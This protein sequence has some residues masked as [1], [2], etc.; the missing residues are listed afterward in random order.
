VP[1]LPAGT[2]TFLF[3]DI[4]KSSRLLAVDAAEMR[5]ALTAH[6]D[7]LREAI[8]RNGG[9]VFETVGDAVYAAFAKPSDAL[10][11]ALASQRALGAE[12][13]APVGAIRARMAIHSG[14]VER[15]D[16]QHYVGEPLFRAGRLLVLGHGGQTLVSG[17]T[18]ML[19][20]ST[21]PASATLRDL[22]EHRLKDIPGYEHVFQLDHPGLTDSFPPLRSLDARPNNL[23]SPLTS[24]I[25]RDR[26]LADLADLLGKGR[27][28][29][30]TG[31]GG[32]GKTRLALELCSRALDGYPDGCWWVDLA[33]LADP[34]LVWPS[35]GTAIG[36]REQP[37]EPL[38]ASIVAYLRERRAILVLDNCEHLVDACAA[39]AEDLLHACHELRLVA[40]SRETLGVAGERVWRTPS[41]SE[42]VDLFLER[43]RATGATIDPDGQRAEIARV[44]ER[45][46]RLPLAIE[47]AAARTR[48]LSIQQIAERLD[49]RFRL[50]TGGSRTAVARQQTLSAAIDWSFSLLD[51]R[52]RVLWQ[53][54]SVF[55]GGFSIDAAERVCAGGEVSEVAILDIVTSLV[56]KSL[57]ITE[58]SARTAVR[59]RMLESLREY[60]GSRLAESGETDAIRSAH[61]DHFLA[62][63]ERGRQHVLG[64]AEQGLWLDRFDG[65]IDNFRAAFRWSIEHAPDV[66]LRLAVALGRFV[67][68]RAH[69]S[70]AVVWRDAILPHLADADAP[71]RAAAL[72]LAGTV[73][74]QRE[75]Y[76]LAI[77]YHTRAVEAFQALGDESGVADAL[78]ALGNDTARKGDDFASRDYFAQTLELDRRAARAHGIA[79]S[80]AGL[81][82]VAWRQGDY[83][84]ARQYYEEAARIRAELG[85]RLGV[86]QVQ[87]DLAHVLQELGETHQAERV[88]TESA[89]TFREMGAR[90]ALTGVNMALAH[91]AADGGEPDRAIALYEEAEAIA[92]E[93]DIRPMIGMTLTARADVTFSLGDVDR[94]AELVRAALE[95]LGPIPSNRGIIWC[96][97]LAGRVALA[98]GDTVQAV[99]LLAAAAAT[100]ERIGL[101]PP[102]KV[103]RQFDADV[104]TL[105]AALGDDAFATAW[106]EGAA[107]SRDETTRCSLAAVSN[108][109]SA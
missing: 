51:E 74:A 45:L 92:R 88:A 56:D 84:P 79:T 91:L 29:T 41:L 105:R 72:L 38:R 33:P 109:R 14:E 8:E 7:L 82:R 98:R 108:P 68:V 39:A 21:L 54:L 36:V 67:I 93:L 47:L 6:H 86:A 34:A 25:G 101:V 24:F 30:L 2:V 19:A 99:R 64:G 9:V 27:L 48:V 94:T 46:D 50:L 87:I 44:C 11:A 71:T 75:E 107:M 95:I 43:A 3:T 63:A 58:P 100:R 97:G 73:H 62:L 5:A 66:G 4:E 81:G 15:R 32:T 106:T 90:G 76:D 1:E 52:E 83:A 61:A 70:D 22:G 13:D 69:V 102:A 104:A 78:R 96:W 59:Y 65:E 55:V 37:G 17:A 57:V 20:R 53:R 60:A 42:A 35:V 28:L 18:E 10:A 12:M 89:T 26:E 77:G 85:D 31:A 23:P 80:Y 49:D 16:A 103:R 40:T